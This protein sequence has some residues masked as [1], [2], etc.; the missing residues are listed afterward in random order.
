MASNV[1]RHLK[2]NHVDIYNEVEESY[3]KIEEQPN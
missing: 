1:R 3:K 2:R